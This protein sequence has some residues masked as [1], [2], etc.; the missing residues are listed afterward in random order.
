MPL[1]PGA[2]CFDYDSVVKSDFVLGMSSHMN[3]SAPRR[4]AKRRGNS[5][6]RTR[7]TRGDSSQTDAKFTG[8]PAR[9]VADRDVKAQLDP[10]AANSRLLATRLMLAA[11][12]DLHDVRFFSLPA[13]LATVLAALFRRTVAGPMSTRCYFISHHTDLL[14]CLLGVFKLL[15]D[16]LD[17]C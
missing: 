16:A 9:N 17:P 5:F 7:K 2:L 12:S 10:I 8:P 4:F 3:T 6:T 13:V 1:P 15:G 11:A 14:V